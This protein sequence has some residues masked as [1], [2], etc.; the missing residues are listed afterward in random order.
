[1]ACSRPG[2]ACGCWCAGAGAGVGPALGGLAVDG[3]VGGRSGADRATLQGCSGPGGCAGRAGTP[4]PRASSTLDA[5]SSARSAGPLCPCPS[6]W[7]GTATRAWCWASTRDGEDDRKGG[8]TVLLWWFEWVGGVCVCGG[9]G[10]GGGGGG[11]GGSAVGHTQDDSEPLLPPPLLPRPPSLP[12]LLRP[13]C[14][15]SYCCCR[16]CRRRRCRHCCSCSCLL[17][18][19][20]PLLPCTACY[21]RLSPD[22]TR[23]DVLHPW[24]HPPHPCPCRSKAL[25][26]KLKQLG[27]DLS[28]EQLNEVF[29]RFIGVADKKKVG[30]WGGGGVPVA[31][32]V[33]CMGGLQ[34][35]PTPTAITSASSGM[36]AAVCMQRYASSGMQAAVPRFNPSLLAVHQ[37]RG[38]PGACERGG[39]RPRRHSHAGRPA[40][41][42][43]V[44][45]RTSRL[46]WVGWARAACERRP[47]RTAAS[48]AAASVVACMCVSSACLSAAATPWVRAPL[49][50]LC[51]PPTPRR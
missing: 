39:A 18:L 46:E 21:C 19:Q 44:L 28:Q 22:S 31:P 26:T 49:C 5:R 7:C 45:R 25:G 47:L 40:G 2:A 32:P 29:K 9:W 8:C 33:R 20:L 41:G 17:P 15:C 27:F 51:P 36:Q 50:P 16:C 11:G 3:C 42:W 10:G 24:P 43:R 6:G 48:T 13:P 38:H 30:G 37:R 23:L 14:C 1:M 4:S 12:Q 35:R 34:T